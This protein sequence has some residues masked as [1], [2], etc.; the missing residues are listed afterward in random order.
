MGKEEEGI[1]IEERVRRLELVFDGYCPWCYQRTIDWIIPMNKSTIDVL[2]SM[3][4][5][6]KTG[7]K[8]N[9]GMK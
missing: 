2:G 6:H 7:H 3:G 9:C 1:S 5:D 8:K 4:I